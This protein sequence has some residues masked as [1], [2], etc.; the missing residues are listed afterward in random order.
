MDFQKFGAFKNQLEEIFTILNEP[1]H[2]C[3]IEKIL[4]KTEQLIGFMKDS[5]KK[6]SKTSVHQNLRDKDIIQQW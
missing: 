2:K 1:I 3:W 6:I 4:I 5:E